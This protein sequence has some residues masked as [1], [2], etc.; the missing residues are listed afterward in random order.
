MR[1]GAAVG[2][3]LLRRA[4]PEARG[5]LPF[6]EVFGHVLVIPTFGEGENLLRALESVP[7]GPM[8]DVLTIVVVNARASSP[9][10]VHDDNR[11]SL[12]ALER[13]SRSR[14]LLVIDRASPGRF[15]PERQGVGLARKIG[16][17]VALALSAA[18]LVRSAWIHGTDADAVLPGDYF[19]RSDESAAALLYPF[20][21]DA[22]RRPELTEASALYEIS[23]RYYVAGLSFARSPYAFH[24]VGSTIAVRASS[25]A[26]AQGYPRRDAAE[27]FYLLNKLAKTGRVQRLAGS[28]IRLEARIS[29]R[30]PFGTGRALARLQASNDSLRLYHPEIFE[31][32]ASWLDVLE[33]F[34]SSRGDPRARIS[35]A[36]ALGAALERMGAWT[37]LREAAHRSKGPE[38]LRRRLHIWFD[39]F[40]TLKLIHALR[41]LGLPSLPWREA[42]MSA[43]FIPPPRAERLTPEEWLARLVALEQEAPPEA[44]VA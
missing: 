6:N 18:G 26:A 12:A 4:E 27:D 2:K 35:T 22:S 21:H 36:T 8:G 30:V 19:E 23:L 31:Q 16:T 5:T 37:A 38:A 20:A 43:P 15:F 25:Y 42:L 14:A 7:P 13:L 33:G 11:R 41:D 44:A 9:A 24:T 28:P 40:R 29:D 1:P 39:A 17:D 10:S 32:L 34:A 3:Y